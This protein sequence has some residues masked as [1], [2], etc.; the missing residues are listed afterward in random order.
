MNI[1]KLAVSA[2][3]AA[4]TLLTVPLEASAGRYKFSKHIGSSYIGTVYVTGNDSRVK[5]KLSQKLPTCSHRSYLN[6]Y[7][8]VR[9]FSNGGYTKWI[10]MNYEGKSRNREGQWVNSTRTAHTKYLNP[11]K[12]TVRVRTNY[13]C[14]SL[15]PLRDV[16]PAPGSNDI[17]RELD[18][19]LSGGCDPTKGIFW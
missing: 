5:I 18:N 6:G 10:R 13:T 1:K 8:E 17:R 16:V 4:S 2:V 15:A 7:T 3:I 19:C 9:F 12:G 14:K 11:D